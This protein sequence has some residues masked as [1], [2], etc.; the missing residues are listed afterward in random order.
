M[1]THYQGHFGP[2][3]PSKVNPSLDCI[4]LPEGLARALL[5]A[6]RDR[7][8]PDWTA[9]L[10][11][12]FEDNVW[13]PERKIVAYRELVVG[14]GK[15]Q[16]ACLTLAGMDDSREAQLRRWDDR[17]GLQIICCEAC[18]LSFELLRQPQDLDRLV[19]E[20]YAF[21]PYPVDGGWVQSLENWRHLIEEHRQ[22]DLHW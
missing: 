19:E 6:T 9:F 3:L 4:I 20:L 13:W 18:S 7:L 15:D 11:G 12:Y 14:P 22:I 2:L 16:F 21:C 5:A 1:S 8:R 10:G 17:Y